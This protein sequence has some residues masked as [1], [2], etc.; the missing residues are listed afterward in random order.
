M[1]PSQLEK[2]LNPKK[3]YYWSKTFS[4]RRVRLTKLLRFR[5]GSYAPRQA[6]PHLGKGLS[7]ASEGP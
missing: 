5:G 4:W 2:I 6:D 7:G 3:N 1:S